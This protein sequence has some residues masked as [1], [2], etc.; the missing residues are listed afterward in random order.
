M[1]HEGIKSL[2]VRG[3]DSPSADG[4]ASSL[5][6]SNPQT[7]HPSFLPSLQP[8]A[9]PPPISP[10]QR[11]Y[12]FL[13]AAQRGMDV[14]DVRAMTPEKH[15]SRLTGPQAMELINALKFGRAPDYQRGSQWGRRPRR[16]S[17]RVGRIVAD[18]RAA[19]G[20]R[21]PFTRRSAIG[22]QRTRPPG[23]KPID[24][25]SLPSSEAMDL[26][27][28]LVDQLAAVYGQSAG[29]VETWLG[30]RHYSHGGPMNVV[31]TSTDCEEAIE[32]LKVI[33]RKAAIA[34]LRRQEKA[35]G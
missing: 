1:K 28:D 20:R 24:I 7:L 33:L 21:P 17:S 15:V 25:Y 13:L 5:K 18:V 16:P 31:F 19:T 23:R 34:A 29:E 12:I 3:G 30:T 32:L 6:P 27:C 8:P 14:D 9:S 22:T 2:R 11:N 10:G 35:E 26:R 4:P